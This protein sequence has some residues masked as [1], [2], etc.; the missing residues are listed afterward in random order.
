M[1]HQHEHTHALPANANSNKT[2]IVGIALRLAS[3]VVEPIVVVTKHSM[4]LLPDAG[5]NLSDVSKLFMSLPAFRF[6]KKN[7]RRNL[8]GVNEQSKT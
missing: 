5:H 7:Q 6:A 3:V 4:S 1:S 2:F 8:R